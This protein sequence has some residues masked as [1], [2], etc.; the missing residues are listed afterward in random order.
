[1]ALYRNSTALAATGS[2]LTAATA[3][4]FTFSDDSVFCE[5]YVSES[6]P[7]TIYGRWNHDD[8]SN[9]DY[10]F[11]LAPGESR[12][13]PEG[14]V[15]NNLTLYSAS[16]QTYNTDFVIKGYTRNK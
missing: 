14:M 8:A 9:T 4:E 2:N 3:A 6:A 12:R 7:A 15:I 11:F 1:M 13:S 16:G 10:D 5:I